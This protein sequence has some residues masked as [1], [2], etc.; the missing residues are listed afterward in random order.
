MSLQKPQ[1]EDWTYL[2]KSGAMPTGNTVR[3]KRKIEE[4]KQDL[5]KSPSIFQVTFYPNTTHEKPTG[6]LFR[7]EPF[8]DDWGFARRS[9]PTS[10]VTGSLS[11]PRNGGAAPLIQ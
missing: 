6:P 3:L 10:M 11:V 8:D 9:M 1:S 2:F 5:S 7:K 4:E